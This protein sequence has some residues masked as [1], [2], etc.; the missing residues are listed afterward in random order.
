MDGVHCPSLIFL[1]LTYHSA[2]LPSATTNKRHLRTVFDCPERFFKMS[3]Y[4]LSF[5]FVVSYE[6]QAIKFAPVQLLALSIFY[7]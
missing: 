1:P 6:F 4:I 3:R 5:R 7:E 2:R